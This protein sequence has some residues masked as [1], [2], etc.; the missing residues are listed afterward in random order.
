MGVVSIDL[1]TNTDVSE[2]QIYKMA[3]GI[4]FFIV[5]YEKISEATSLRKII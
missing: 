4:G 1:A 2:S 3:E 5:G